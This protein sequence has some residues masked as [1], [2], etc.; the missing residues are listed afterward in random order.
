MPLAK[1]ALLA[2]AWAQSKGWVSTGRVCKAS[3]GDLEQDICWANTGKALENVILRR[4]SDGPNTERVLRAL[5][6]VV[7][8]TNAYILVTNFQVL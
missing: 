5:Y 1:A 2:G 4:G 6:H 7:L 3:G 8:K